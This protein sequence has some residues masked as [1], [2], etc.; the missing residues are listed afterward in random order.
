MVVLFK[1]STDN[2]YTKVVNKKTNSI[3]QFWKEVAGFTHCYLTDKSIV[4]DVGVGFRV[5]MLKSFLHWTPDVTIL[6]F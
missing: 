1:L 5:K 2:H 6:V 3:T 4:F